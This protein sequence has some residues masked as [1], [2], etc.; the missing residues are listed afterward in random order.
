MSITVFVIG[1]GFGKKNL[2]NTC[3]CMFI[4]ALFTIAKMQKHCKCQWTDEWTNKMLHIHKQW[5]SLGFGKLL[6]P[7]TYLFALLMN[8]FPSTSHVADSVPA[9][10]HSPFSGKRDWLLLLCPHHRLYMLCSSP[11]C[12][13]VSG[14]LFSTILLS[15]LPQPFPYIKLPPQYYDSKI[16]LHP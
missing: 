3:V 15:F 2:G 4:A 10:R 14:S 12:L 7:H 16:F 8:T 5:K 13:E 1:L 9:S 11:K 6:C